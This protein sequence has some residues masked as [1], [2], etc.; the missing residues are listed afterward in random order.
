MK[1][2]YD[3]AIS[4][5]LS[6]IL[7]ALSLPLAQH[8]PAALKL[9]RSCPSP[10]ESASGHILMSLNMKAA[11]SYASMGMAGPALVNRSLRAA[12]SNLYGL[13]RLVEYNVIE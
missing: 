9:I 1:S 8:C 5:S 11:H 13:R 7:P 4:Y 6:I 10:P 3:L 12:A 2:P